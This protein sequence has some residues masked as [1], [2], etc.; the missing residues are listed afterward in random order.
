MPTESLKFRVKVEGA[1]EARREVDRFNDEL[2]RSGEQSESTS[3]GLG[4]VATKLGLVAAG[5]A[6]AVVAFDR[7]ADST[8]RTVGVMSHLRGS[9]DAAQD[10]VGGMVSK[11]D[12]A[13]TR[14]AL[15]QRGFQV[16]DDQFASLAVVAQDYAQA[17]G[18]DT[19]EAIEQLGDALIGVSAEELERFGLTLDTSKTKSEQFS[20]ALA[21]LSVRADEVGGGAASSAG[22]WQRF[23]TAVDDALTSSM[24]MSDF[25][26]Q[27]LISAIRGVDDETQNAAESMRQWDEFAKGLRTT[28]VSVIGTVTAAGAALATFGREMSDLDAALTPGMQTGDQ[29][30]GEVFDQTLRDFLAQYVEGEGGGSTRAIGAGFP[31][32]G[33]G[34]L[35]TNLSPEEQEAFAGAFGGGGAANTNGRG[36]GGS[37]RVQAQNDEF[38]ALIDGLTQ[39]TDLEQEESNI[40]REIAQEEAEARK[41]AEGEKLE[42]VREAEEAATEKA[43]QAARERQE[44]AARILEQQQAEARERTEQIQADAESILK[45]AVSGITDA[46][47]SIIAGT[48]SADEAFMGMLSSFLEMISQQAAL[49]AAKEFAAAIGSFASYQYD[50]GALHLAAGIAWTGVAVAAGAGAVATAPAEAS[51][52]SPQ[53]DTGAAQGSSGGNTFVYNVNG[54]VISAG[55]EARAGRSLT[56]LQDKGATR[57]GRAA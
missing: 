48:K 25:A 34:S 7:F 47:S 44:D 32:V 53:A 54:P 50:A 56:R 31:G 12:L 14:N 10:A 22:S 21:Q 26:G 9:V 29:D 13:I 11:F 16:T 33:Q 52:A 30:A 17:I 4:S 43:K 23:K 42:A 20:D 27:Q 15:V 36:G 49:E 28:F 55:T 37:A 38:A 45:P 8:E 19:T 5:A 35:F 46:L 40:R 6:A 57:F 18:V 51:P 41:E 1:E 3:T 39:F 24:E 2:G